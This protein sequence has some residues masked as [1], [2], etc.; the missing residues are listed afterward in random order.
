MVVRP[1]SEGAAAARATRR[2]DVLKRRVACPG[3][4]TDREWPDGSRIARGR[5]LF[6]DVGGGVAG[7]ERSASTCP[8]AASTS[9]RPAMKWAQSAPLTEIGQNVG[10][11]F[12]RRVFVEEGDGVHGFEGAAPCRRGRA[13]AI[14]GRDGPLA[15]HAG[16]GVERQDQDVAQ[17][18]RLFEQADV[19]GM[20]QVVAAVG[21]D[22]GFPCCFQRARCSPV[23]RGCKKVP[24]DFQ[25]SSR[26]QTPNPQSVEKFSY[27]RPKIVY[28]EVEMRAFFNSLMAALVVDGA[29]LGE[30][31]LLPASSAGGAKAQLLPARQVRSSKECKTQGLRNFVKADPVVKVAARRSGNVSTRSR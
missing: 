15:A 7:F 22:D 2:N 6:H 29:V 10:D 31:F 5:I 3:Q 13:S 25:F 21:E 4:E 14:S 26:H 28:D 23:R 16:V 12:A 9:S 24:L 27:S 8:P 1:E 20:Q 19:A 11:Q 18:A 17:R 30:L